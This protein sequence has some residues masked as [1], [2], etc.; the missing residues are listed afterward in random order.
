MFLGDVGSQ[1]LGFLLS[2][3]AI[4]TVES[5]GGMVSPYMIFVLFIPL[6]YDTVFTL[7]R[8]KLKHE[9][10]FQGHR[11]HLYQLLNR[12]GWG[13]APVSLLYFSFIVIGGIGALGMYWLPDAEHLY[14]LLPYGFLY[15]TYTLVVLRHAHTAGV[16]L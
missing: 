15:G 9:D 13:H 12:S 8:R 5:S 16:R 11:S 7:I 10:I 1:F 2:V 4:V 6:I 14:V 3:L